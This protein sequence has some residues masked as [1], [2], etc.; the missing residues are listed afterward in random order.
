M[1]PP[2]KAFLRANLCP[3]RMSL[4]ARGYWHRLLRIL[5]SPLGFIEGKDVPLGGNEDV[6]ACMGFVEADNANEQ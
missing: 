1:E 4:H 3:E 2:C 5:G 6:T